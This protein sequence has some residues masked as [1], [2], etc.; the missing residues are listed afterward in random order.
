MNKTRLCILIV[1]V[2]TLLGSAASTQ[3]AQFLFTPELNISEEY[4]DNIFLANENETE[5]FITTTGLNLT[6]EV[7]V[8]TAGLR[9]NY[10][11]SYSMFADNEDLDYWR[12]SASLTVWDD[13][14]RRTRI[15]FNNTYLETEDPRDNSEEIELEDPLIGPVIDVDLNR[16]GRN[17]YRRNVAEARLTNQFGANDQVYAAVEYSLLRDLDTFPD[18]PVDDYDIWKPSFGLDYWFTVRWGL[19]L[20]GYYSDRDYVDQDDREEY[21]GTMRLLHN[22]TRHLSGFVEYRHTMLDFDQEIDDEDYQIY[23]PSIGVRYQ[24]QETA[25]I[26]LSGGYYIQDFDRT[27]QN[28]EG[29]VVN[30]SIYKR[31][32]FPTGFIDLT[33]SSGYDIEDTGTQDLGLNIYYSARLDLT[34]NFTSIF[35]G[36]A[37]GAFRYDDYPNT[38]PERTDKAVNAGASLGYQALQ[39]MNIGLT[40]NYVQFISDEETREYTENS[41]LLS[42]NI[43][44]PRPLRLN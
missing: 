2:L 43:A 39:W 29:F 3:A 24:F 37:F 34:K 12:H 33:G 4:S 6:G 42:V 27:D 11:P 5:D 10:L 7:L 16:R 23:E 9:L 25:H 18:E 44:S 22:F 26:M 40:Y 30:S 41:I 36:N 13:I 21:S 1:I 14:S 28:E 19:E 38:I 17:R 31:W 8:R 35:T 15:E 20:E 32:A